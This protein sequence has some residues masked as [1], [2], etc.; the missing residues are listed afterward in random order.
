MRKL[1]VGFTVLELMMVMAIGVF[2]A[3][4]SWTVYRSARADTRVNQHAD[5]L[6]YVV[7]SADSVTMTR[8]DY[9]IPNGSGA[10]PITAAAIVALTGTQNMFP[11]GSTGST[12]GIYGPLGQVAVT[13]ASSAG[14]AN[15]LL[16]LTTTQVPAREC[17]R[18]VVRMAPGVYDMRINNSLVRLTPAPENG[19]LGRSDAEG[20]QVATLCGNGNNTVTI[21]KLKYINFAA[22]RHDGFGEFTGDEEAVI[23]PLYNRMEAAMAA[24]EAAQSAL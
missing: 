16:V 18:L 7:A 17:S 9:Q 6:R 14:S 5:L 19:S 20:G 10:T 21:R 1:N 8:N 23:T 3:T 15:D 11:S 2:V 4:L 24:R 12:A 22:M 13:T